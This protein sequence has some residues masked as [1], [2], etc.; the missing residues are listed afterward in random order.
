MGG[1]GDTSGL[2]KVEEEELGVTEGGGVEGC[3]VE[4]LGGCWLVCLILVEG[5]LYC[6]VVPDGIVMVCGPGIWPWG[7]TEPATMG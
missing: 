2:G 4:S 1:P 6:M 5:T 3:P 7:P